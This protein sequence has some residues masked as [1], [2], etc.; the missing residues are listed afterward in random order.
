MDDYNVSVSQSQTQS[1]AVLHEILTTYR[2]IFG[3]SKQSRRLF[4]K[5]E[6]IKACKFGTLDPVLE[7]LC[8]SEKHQLD[9]FLVAGQGQVH[10]TASFPHFG[11]RLEKLQAYATSRKPTRIR[12]KWKDRRNR[13]EWAAFWTLLIIGA[14]SILLSVVQIALAAAQLQVALRQL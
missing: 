8:G 9:S 12:E 10:H 7:R 11:L 4:H 2:I 6:K 5:R 14:L 13:A 1:T 3:Q